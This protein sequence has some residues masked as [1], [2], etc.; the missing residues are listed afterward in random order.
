MW[1]AM[2]L[3]KGTPL[4]ELL[5]R[6][7][8]LPLERFVPLFERLCEVIQS[9]HDQGIVHRDIKPSNV[10]VITRAGRLMPKL[11][12]FGIARL[13]TAPEVAPADDHEPP[14]RPRAITVPGALDLD[15]T[16]NRSTSCANRTTGGSASRETTGSLTH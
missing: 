12:D 4:D 1:I 9:A 6:S 15:R 11:L 2:E 14:G 16:I 3:V 10:M 7:G 5:R 13:V 8:P